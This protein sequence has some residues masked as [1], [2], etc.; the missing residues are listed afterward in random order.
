MPPILFAA[1]QTPFTK[2]AH[3]IFPNWMANGI[4]AGSFAFY[5]AYD[6][7]H[8]AMHH[9]KL[10]TVRLATSLLLDFDK[11]RSLTLSVKFEIVHQEAKDMAHGTPL[12]RAQPWLRVG[13]CLLS[14]SSRVTALTFNLSNSSVTSSVWDKVFGTE[15]SFSFFP[16][17]LLQTA[18]SLFLSLNSD[19]LASH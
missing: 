13:L 17:S 4:I 18:L 7:L 5:V 3:S 6:M 10:P 9:S 15:V 2:L 16:L 11:N 12:Q 1:L 8:Y 19:S 14:P